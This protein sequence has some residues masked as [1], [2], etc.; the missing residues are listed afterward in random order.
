[1][2]I[3]YIADT[4]KM[5]M[6]DFKCSSCGTVQERIVKLEDDAPACKKCGGE[7]EKQISGGIGVKFKGP[8][9]HVN[10]YYCK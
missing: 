6:F 4:I 9:F 2:Q 3:Q 8:G 5:P 1:M 7:T 10:D